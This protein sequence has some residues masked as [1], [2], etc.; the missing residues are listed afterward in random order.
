MSSALAPRGF[1][2][3]GGDDRPKASTEER[4]VAAPLPAPAAIRASLS[5]T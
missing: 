2:G 3:V 1:K 5:C 4:G